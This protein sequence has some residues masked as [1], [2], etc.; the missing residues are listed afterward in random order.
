MFR[1]PLFVDTYWVSEMPVGILKFFPY[2]SRDIT[3]K[4]QKP[5]H[6][7]SFSK[8][9]HCVFKWWDFCFSGSGN[10]N[11][12]LVCQLSRDVG[13]YADSRHHRNSRLL[14]I[15]YSRQTSF[16]NRG[17]GRKLFKS[18]R[19]IAVESFILFSINKE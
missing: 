18:C 13:P 1:S 2:S 15:L 19:L 12:F 14:L 6:Y 8:F 16:N 3:R 7:S 9:D 5:F 11:S 17:D 4:A 10:G